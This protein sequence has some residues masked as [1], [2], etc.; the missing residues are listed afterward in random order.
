AASSRKS[1][2]RS[3]DRSGDSTTEKGILMRHR[4]RCNEPTR[5]EY[6]VY[7]S[8]GLAALVAV[9]CSLGA[10]L[11]FCSR[12]DQIAR[13]FMVRSAVVEGE[14]VSFTNATGVESSVLD[15]GQVAQTN[16]P[17]FAPATDRGVGAPTSG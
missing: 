4:L 13:W 7:L 5:M 12:L 17:A 1:T 8:L 10:T 14:K 11:D 9:F 16:L 3:Q 6:I 2:P 15:A